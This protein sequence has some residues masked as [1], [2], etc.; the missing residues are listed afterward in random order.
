MNKQY[1][2]LNISQMIVNNEEE[3]KEFYKSFNKATTASCPRS[4]AI[5]IGL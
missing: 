3:K 1:D 5:S 2:N 4:V